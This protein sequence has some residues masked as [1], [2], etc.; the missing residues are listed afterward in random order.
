M[1]IQVTCPGCLSRF[2]VSDKFAGKKGPCP[3]CKKEISIPTKAEE[4]VIHAPEP[5]GPKDS[6]GKVIL[7][8]IRRT[9]TLLTRRL[10][11]FIAGAVLFFLGELFLSVS[12][13]PAMGAG[14]WGW[15]RS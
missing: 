4:V 2:S 14:C 13:C 12:R 1:P 8:P 7:K 9:D 6:Q 10:L 5:T 15:G 3:K 11:V